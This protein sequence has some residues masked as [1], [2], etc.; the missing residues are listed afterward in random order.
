MISVTLWLQLS[1][2]SPRNPGE[3]VTGGLAGQLILT[4][5]AGRR[6][7]PLQF[8]SFP[9]HVLGSLHRRIKGEAN[10]VSRNSITT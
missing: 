10:I 5:V 3:P 2:I 8:P 7:V 1:S 6:L 4:P 9:L